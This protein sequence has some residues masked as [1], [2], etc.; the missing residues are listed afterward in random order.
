MSM[1][2]LSGSLPRVFDPL[3][4]ARAQDAA[5]D[6]PASATRAQIAVGVAVVPMVAVTLWLASTSDY[7]QRPMAAGVYWSYLVAAPMLTGLYWWNRRPASRFGLLLIAFGASAWLVSWQGASSS[8]AFDIGV[9]AE[10]PSWLLTIY[11]FLAFPA[12]R[13]ETTAERVLVALC[14][15][16]VLLTFL[17]WALLAP[18][19]AGAGVLTRCAPTCPESVVQVTSWPAGAQT[20][21]DAEMYAL[22]TLTVAVFVAYLT[23]LVRASRPQRRALV[24]V[25]AT[26]LLFLPAFFVYHFSAGILE[27]DA[28]TLDT[29]AWG[30]VLTRILLPLGFLIALLQAEAFAGSALRTLLTRLAARPTP[31]EWRDAIAGALDDPRLQLGFC[32][33]ATASFRA[34][35]GEVLAPETI[36]PHRTWVPVDRDRHPVAAMVIDERLTEDPELVTAAAS[37]TLLAVENGALEGELRA[38]RARILEAGNAERRRIERDLHDSA[39]QRLVALRIHLALVGEKLDTPEERDMLDG[40]GTEVDEAI[41]E[42]RDVARGLYPQIVGQ[43]GLPA[44]LAAVARRSAI[45]VRIRTDGLSR[46]SEELETTVYFCCLECVQNAAKHAGADASVTVRLGEDREGIWFCVEDDGP[47]FDLAKVERGAGLANLADRV[48]AIGG[49]LEIDTRPGEG[50]RITGELPLSS[51]PD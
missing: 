14:G 18:V 33:P 49:T 31:A 34:P 10:G 39:Q 51:H 17:P 43:L 11:L 50:T 32:E 36:A 29:L 23:R 26:S 16:A 41:E 15:L 38:S 45:P 42:L 47:G 19:I 40:L 20:F 22:L 1:R 48:E 4:V 21:G 24:A 27:L 30:V 3:P 28:S 44:A 6:S 2:L 46:H 9:L 25:A 8:L 35:S 13:L 7:L 12:G 37:A 5:V